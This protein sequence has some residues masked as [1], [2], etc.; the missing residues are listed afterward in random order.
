VDCSAL[1]GRFGGGGHRAAAGAIIDG[2]FEAVH[3]KVRT[4]VDQAWAARAS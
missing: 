1:A 4:A 2:P 3:D